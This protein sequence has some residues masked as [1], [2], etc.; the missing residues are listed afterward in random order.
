MKILA[1]HLPQFHEIPENNEWWGEGFTEWTNLDKPNKVGGKLQPLLGQYNMLDKQTLIMQ[2]NLAKEY[3]VYG[4]CYY[5]YYFEGKK[6]LEKPVELLLREKDIAQKFCF[7]WANHSWYKAKQGVKELLIEQTYGNEEQ[8]AEHFEYLKDFFLD[9]RYIKV[10][11]KPLFSV[12]AGNFEQAEAIRLFFDKK[13]KEIGFEGIHWVATWHAEELKMPRQEQCDAVL[14][15]E[16]SFSMKASLLTRIFNKFRRVFKQYLPKRWA[17][18]RYSP[19]IIMENSLSK[20]KEFDCGMPFYIGAYSMWDNTY[21]HDEWGYIIEKPSK[22]LFYKYINGLNKIADERGIEF[23][24]FNAW[25]E[26][27]EGMILEPDTKNG[28]F[29]LDIIKK[30]MEKNDEK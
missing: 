24:F 8:W 9:E 20:L 23:C 6:L 22:R 7:C 11:N 5:H 15:R 21:R 3:G 26:W 17:I 27:A 10:N 18:Q 16:P 2:T 12:F 28:Y 29:F 25:N 1:F 4:F 14:L 30:V 19:N 13:C